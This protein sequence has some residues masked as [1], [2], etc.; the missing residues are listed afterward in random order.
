MLKTPPKGVGDYD[1]KERAANLK[2]LANIG[3]KPKNTDEAL[4][5]EDEMAFVKATMFA[6]KLYDKVGNVEDV[7]ANLPK[8]FIRFKDELEQHLTQKFEG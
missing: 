6:E 5:P 7:L 4:T 1:P 8:Q 3:P 2:R